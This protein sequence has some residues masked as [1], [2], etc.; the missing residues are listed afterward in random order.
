MEL[1]TDNASPTLP[2]VAATQRKSAWSEDEQVALAHSHAMLG[3][4]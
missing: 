4:R 2:K 1:V 3:N